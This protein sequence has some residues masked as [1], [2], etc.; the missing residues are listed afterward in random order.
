MKHTICAIPLLLLSPY[1]AFSSNDTHL[2]SQQ[3]FD[4]P[5]LFWAG[6][7]SVQDSMITVQ[8]SVKDEQNN[9]IAGTIVSIKG[10]SV[11]TVSDDQ[12]LFTL[13]VKPDATLI[14]NKTDFARQE[15]PVNN[16]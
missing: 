9:A 12:G 13:E 16:R 14:F 11:N 3:L 7:F 5:A 6:T 10:E 15:E 8:G 2:S 1:W 4:K